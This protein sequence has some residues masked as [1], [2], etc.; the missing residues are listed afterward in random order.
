MHPGGRNQRIAAPGPAA[1]A[2]RRAAA[3]RCRVAPAR[4][5][6][7]YIFHPLTSALLA[8]AHSEIYAIAVLKSM[9]DA[10]GS[11]R[12]MVGNWNNLL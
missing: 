10:N 8:W 7:D 4:R 9:V 11:T 6:L 12:L 3:V 2:A 1:A 5:S